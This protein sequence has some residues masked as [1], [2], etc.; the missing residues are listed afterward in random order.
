MSDVYVSYASRDRE[1]VRPILDALRS[2]GLG[3]V[4]DQ[5]PVRGA[6]FAEA[7]AAELDAARC[8]L[9]VWS[10]AAED[11]QWVQSEMRQVMKAW[12]SDRLVLAALDD[13]P[14][15]TGLKD[16][17]ALSADEVPALVARVREAVSPAALSPEGLAPEAAPRT[18]VPAASPAPELARRPRAGLFVG[19]AG[20]A[21][22]G[23]LAL[24]WGVF[25][26]ASAPPHPSGYHHTRPPSAE[27]PSEPKIRREP[28][29]PAPSEPKVGAEP[30][31]AVP[32]P[33][34][35]ASLN[36]SLPE[37]FG[38]LAAGLL[39]GAGLVWFV[40]ARGRSRPSAPQP[41]VSPPLQSAQPLPAGG[42]QLFI[43]YSHK[44]GTA[45]ESLV[46][47]LEG[48]GYPV[49]IDREAGGAQRYAGAI[50][51]A[52]RGSKLVALMCSENAFASDHVIRE[53]YVA[54]DFKKPFIAFQLDGTEFPDEILYFL[55]GFPRVPIGGLS[56]DQLRADIA[57]L[58][59]RR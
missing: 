21:V 4:D 19:L 56:P 55:T 43:S 24:G 36:K 28:A 1:A 16:L 37:L 38:V 49:W 10:K 27:E 11:S 20:L 31:P 50:V 40:M 17:H 58:A 51:G 41:I 30:E 45:V 44:D 13:T 33:P 7:L 2:A 59:E 12:S 57:R 15:P 42:L 18:A 35:E 39:A 22:I 3:V 6:D 34:A 14:L 8:V 32:A 52:I 47:K 53:V 9:I 5:S 25:N 26:K 46:E 48:M 54:G 23:A 29:R